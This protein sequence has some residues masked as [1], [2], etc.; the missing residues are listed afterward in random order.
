MDNLIPRPWKQDSEIEIQFF[1]PTINQATNPTNEKIKQIKSIIITHFINCPTNQPTNQ[2]G[3]QPFKQSCQNVLLSHVT[4]LMGPAD[5]VEVVS[6]EELAHDVG[7]EGEADATVVL[8]PTLYNLAVS[9]AVSCPWT[10]R[11]GKL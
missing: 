5:K 2:S 3:Y 8:A 10:M 7:P 1:N 4:N 9:Q 11:H 6:V